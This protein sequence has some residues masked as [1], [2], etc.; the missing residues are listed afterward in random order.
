VLG[1]IFSALAEIEYLF[2]EPFHHR[3]KLFSGS[4]FLEGCK[5]MPRL[6]MDENGEACRTGEVTHADTHGWLL[7]VLHHH[8]RFM[9]PSWMEFYK[10]PYD[11]MGK[12]DHQGD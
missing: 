6:M 3:R 12:N 2:H 5:H 1:F 7:S 11:R 4:F 9:N 10:L 8:I